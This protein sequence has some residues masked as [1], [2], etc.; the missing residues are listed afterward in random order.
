MTTENINEEK[1]KAFIKNLG[2]VL[3]FMLLAGILGAMFLP[4]LVHASPI[5]PLDK[6]QTCAMFNYTEK[7][8]DKYWCEW[9]IEGNWTYELCFKNYTLIINNTINQTANYTINITQIMKDYNLTYANESIIYQANFSDIKNYTD[10]QVM[11]LRDSILD[12]LANQTA[13]NDFTFSSGYKIVKSE[14]GTVTYIPVTPEEPFNWTMAAVI[15]AIV[16]ITIGGMAYV[17][18]KKPPAPKSYQFMKQFDNS[19]FFGNEKKEEKKISPEIDNIELELKQLKD[20]IQSD[21]KAK[22]KR[23]EEP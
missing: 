12:R 10:S 20:E 21:K 7:Q 9:F 23:T 13:G 15:V 11:A 3:F 19:K 2:W 1:G 4:K 5:W 6:N 22:N 16:C 17:N 8:C 18:M 14:N